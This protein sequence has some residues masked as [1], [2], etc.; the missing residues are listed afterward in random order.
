[1]LHDDHYTKE[2]LYAFNINMFRT[3]HKMSVNY[4][5]YVESSHMLSP[6]SVIAHVTV[7]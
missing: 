6:L 3:M 1:M 5:S 2:N 7:E 4:C